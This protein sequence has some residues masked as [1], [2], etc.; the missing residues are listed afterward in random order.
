MCGRASLTKQEK[1]LEQRFN[2]SFYTEDILRYN[3]L[4]NFNLAPTQTHPILIMENGKHFQLMKWG[5]IPSWA[6]DE[7]IGSK[8]INARV[9]GLLEKSFFKTALQTRR[10]LVPLD[11]FYEWKTIQAKTKIPFR[12]QTTNQEIFSVAGLYDLWKNNK[13]EVIYSFTIITLP[14]NEMMKKIHDRMPAILDPDAESLWIDH[15]LNMNQSLE[16]LSP[17]PSELMHM[18]ELS[19]LV[20]KVSANGPELLVPAK[21]T[22]SSN[23]LFD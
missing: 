5:L 6:K 2:A 9:E 12:I 18:T 21:S 4:P 20:N 1:E 10:C 14:A 19:P 7:K 13:G 15:S 8:M 23:T 16:L 3:P 22:S 17:Y 11:G